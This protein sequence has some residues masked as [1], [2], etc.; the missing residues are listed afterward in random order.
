[1]AIDVSTPLGAFSATDERPPEVQR[2]VDLVQGALYGP[3]HRSV[4]RAVVVWDS[5]DLRGGPPQPTGFFLMRNF[6]V[7]D[8]GPASGFHPLPAF[9]LFEGFT[10]ALTLRWVART[11]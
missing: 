8:H 11:V 7:I 4:G 2:A 9:Q 3:K 6:A 5:Y 1:M 10:S